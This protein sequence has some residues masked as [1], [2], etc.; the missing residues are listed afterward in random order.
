MTT[1]SNID[2]RGQRIVFW[3]QHLLG[4]GHVRRT[5]R[6]AHG[7]ADAGADVIV[8]SGGAPTHVEV[9]PARFVQLDPIRC[10]PGDFKTLR[11]A[12][13][14]LVD[15]A[16]KARRRDQALALLKETKPTAVIFEHFPFG[17]RQMRFEVLPMLDWIAA[18]TPRP[19]VFSSVR[20][21]LVQMTSPD[22]VAWTVNMVRDHMD[23]VFVHGD[24]GF[25]PL[26]A[27]FPAA[28]DMGH[29]LAY[30]GYVGL[31]DMRMPPRKVD[32]AEGAIIVSA[33]GGAAG[34]P[35]FD[36]ALSAAA[37]DHETDQTGRR[38]RMFVGAGD[39]KF[40]SYQQVATPNM[41]VEA[42]RPDFPEIL[43]TAGASLSQCGYNTAMELVQ[44]NVPAVFL[45][46]ETVDETEQRHRAEALAATGWAQC[47]PVDAATPQAVLDAVIAAYPKRALALDVEGAWGTVQRF[48]EFIDRGH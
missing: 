14:T 37:L 21:V 18:Q 13:G 5:V 25:L 44:A 28:A 4:T 38:W 7:L 17:R 23:G 42:T 46:F 16:F 27:S 43:A 19:F 10:A 12:D 3:V 26:D 32:R 47:L 20:D 40:Q 6:L 36:L 35:V 29:K 15:A 48:S 33:G 34:E 8:A 11:H 24:A 31:A 45:P 1:G 22:R 39:P 41:T 30:T 9:G 2:L